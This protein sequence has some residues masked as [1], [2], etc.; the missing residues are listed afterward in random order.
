MSL[1]SEELARLADDYFRGIRLAHEL[2]CGECGFNLITQPYSGRCPECGNDYNA[3]PTV[4]KGI[5]IPGSVVPPIW[6][7]VL[8]IVSGLV[9]AQFVRSAVTPLD[10]ERL[11]VAVVVLLIPGYFGWR[12]WH[13]TAKFLKQRAIERYIASTWTD[14]TSGRR[15]ER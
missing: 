3:R 10:M 13:D 6:P 9:S 12:V 11:F 5:F 4:M 8:L 15:A 7:A 2:H 14:P 1:N